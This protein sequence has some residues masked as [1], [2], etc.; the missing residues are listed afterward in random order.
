MELSKELGYEEI[1]DLLLSKANRETGKSSRD[2]VSRVATYWTYLDPL[3]PQFKAWLEAL[4]AT[5]Y[6]STFVDAGYDLKF[7]STYGL[8]EEDLNCLSIPTT[9][10]GLR[11]KLMK[12]YKLDEFYEAEENEDEEEDE[13]DEED[14][15]E[16]DD[17][18]EEE[19]DD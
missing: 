5:E 16:E 18:E 17:E 2:C 15:E 12:L 4:G 7:I 3:L 19:E 6:L 9:K 11:R 14:G 8:S 10:M 1:T 13:E